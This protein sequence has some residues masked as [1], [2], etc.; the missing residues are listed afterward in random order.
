MVLESEFVQTTESFAAKEDIQVEKKTVSI[1]GINGGGT[2][3]Y[4]AGRARG[5]HPRHD[6]N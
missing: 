6:E 3:P 2:N 1:N 4:A 5:T